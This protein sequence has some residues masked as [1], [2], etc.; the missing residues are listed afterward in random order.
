ME[1]TRLDHTRNAPREL[2]AL[3]DLGQETDRSVHRVSLHEQGTLWLVRSGELDLFVVEGHDGPWHH[4]GRVPSGTAFLSPPPGLGP[5]LV[6]R[7]LPGSRLSR[8]PLHE[9]S[10]AIGP[11]GENEPALEALTEGIGRGLSL[12]MGFVREGLPPQE[13]ET[14][15]P[16]TEAALADNLCARPVDGPVWLEVV[17][18]E[19]RISD[20]QDA[21]GFTRGEILILGRRD[22]ITA[23]TAARVRVHTL[24]DFPDPARLWPVAR[25]LEDR[26]LRMGGRAVERRRQHEERRINAGRKANLA[27]AAQADRL[28]GGA[29]GTSGHALSRLVLPDEDATTAA[30]RIVAQAM[31]IDVPRHETPAPPLQTGPIEQWARH[32][33]LRSRVVALDGRWWRRNIGPLI[34]HVAETRAPVALLW[35]R[36][37]YEA[38]DPVSGSVTVV[39]RRTAPVVA[40]Q[41]VMLYRP[42]PEGPI[43]K[44]ALVRAG[45]RGAGGD[46]RAVVVTM[47]IAVALSTLVPVGT[48][49]VLGRFVPNAE[50]TMIIQASAVI[51]MAVAASAAFGIIQNLA[52]LRLEGRFEATLQTLVW[53]RLLRLPAGFFKRWS[54]GELSRAALGVSDIR[55]TLMGISSSVPYHAAVAL[56]NFGVLLWISVPLGLLAA[57]FAAV[58]M[59][60]FALLAKAQMTWQTKSLLQG[61][62]LTDK[63]F[64]MLRGLP[65]LRVAAAEGRAY[66]DWAATFSQQK[67]MQKRIGRHQNA[68]TVFNAGFPPLC[69]LVF[70]VTTSNT[71]DAIS[72][73]GFLTYNASLTLML[74]SLA[75]VTGGI[76]SAIAVIPMFLR[77]QPILTELMESSDSSTAPGELSGDIE[78]SHLTF[79]YAR[80]LPPVLDGVSFRVRPGEF[81]A[82]VGASGSGKSTLLRLLLGFEKPDAGTVL[83]DGQDLSSLDSGAVRRQCGVVLQQ[84]QHSNG[85][86]LQ[87]IT[88]GL[89]YSLDEAWEAAELAGL[90]ED[91]EAMPMTMHTYIGDTSTLSGGQRQRLAIAH[92]L[93]RRPRMLFFDEATSALD[94]ATQ[95]IVTRATKQLK[96][97]RIVIAHRLSTVMDADKIIVLS[98]GRV[99]QYGPPGELL[100]DSAGL[101]HQLVHRQMQ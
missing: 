18:G 70:F 1:L 84:V 90:R 89:N 17:S 94:N 3:A 62:R 40:P 28:L 50:N 4:V 39:D 72:I 65:K 8:I 10:A 64:Q 82:V 98:Q 22:W 85:S 34:G 19:V 6:V 60:T 21:P 33:R 86:I 49:I 27:A 77:L 101:F 63:V 57:V 99:V 45:L 73:P 80:N 61:Y 78:V 71:P 52:L 59:A 38:V 32:S 30:C 67:D 41:A 69:L 93:I 42:L 68:I 54:T 25:L 58:G 37:G 75:Q 96:A 46:I 12:L 66:A 79:G 23:T 11:P 91:I 74:T 87:A 9:V 5:E 47:L 92:A 36:G 48:G 53:D 51:L 35:R 31:G 7:P 20:D 24:R 55:A 97:T 100:A 76:T 14:L 29:L 44:R 43:G 15:E 13:F 2:S 16:G 56:V 88:G 81:L 83:Y 26:L 95:Q